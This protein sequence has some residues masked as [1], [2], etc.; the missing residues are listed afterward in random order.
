MVNYPNEK[1]R[2]N[3]VS[4]NESSLALVLKE[5]ERV[6]SRRGHQL[7]YLR[8]WRFTAEGTFMPLLPVGT[9]G[10]TVA[11][12]SIHDRQQLML[13]GMESD[14]LLTALADGS[15]IGYWIRQCLHLLVQLPHKI[16]KHPR[17]LASLTG[18]PLPTEVPASSHRG[19]LHPHR[20]A[21][22]STSLCELSWL[23]LS[24]LVSTTGEITATNQIESERDSF[25]HRCARHYTASQYRIGLLPLS[26][27]LD[28]LHWL[29]HLCFFR[30][31]HISQSISLC[32]CTALDPLE[33]MADDVVAD[34]TVNA[35]VALTGTSL[36][37]GLVSPLPSAWA[38]VTA[39]PGAWPCMTAPN[40]RV[41]MRVTAF[42]CVA[43]RGLPL[44][45]WL[46]L[47]SL[48]D[49]HAAR[50]GAFGLCF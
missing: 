26:F 50:E 44:G 36:A 22:Q 8:R 21:R 16:C 3:N 11:V 38:H 5:R 15:Q 30:L 43:A 13:V 19:S 10:I 20:G 24:S 23:H 7:G 47:I 12:R 35:D 1:A 48:V 34:W 32:S 17:Y 4:K 9:G 37:R 25:R 18:T 31:P 2:R 49:D 33:N 41:A 40:W 45:T 42:W 27:S 28:I 46:R 29:H 6:E 39:S 14:V